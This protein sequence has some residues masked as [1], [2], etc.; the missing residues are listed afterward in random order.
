VHILAAA[1]EKAG[2]P[3]KDKILENLHALQGF[4]GVTGKIT[5]NAQGDAAKQACVAEI[6]EGVPYFLKCFEPEQQTGRP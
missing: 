1:I 6:R 5:F 4:E 3:D 2:S